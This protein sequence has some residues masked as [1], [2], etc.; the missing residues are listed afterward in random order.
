[1]LTAT[2]QRAVD[3]FAKSLATLSD[4][5]RSMPIIRLG[6]IIETP[7]PRAATTLA[8][9]A[10]RAWQPKPRCDIALRIIKAVTRRG[11]R[12]PCARGRVAHEEHNAALATASMADDDL[13]IVGAYCPGARNRS[14][15][16]SRA[17][18]YP[19][20]G[21][22]P[23]AA[24]VGTLALYPAMVTTLRHLHGPG[25]TTADGMNWCRR[26]LQHRSRC[27]RR[28]AFVPALVAAAGE[29][30]S[31]RFLEFFAAN[32][33]N[34]HTRRAYCPRRGGIPGLVRERR[35]AVDRRRPAG[36]CRD[37]DRG[38]R[39]ASWPRR[40]SSNGSPRSAICSIGWSTARSCRSTRRI[41]ARAAPRRHD[42]AN[43]GARSGRSAR[44]ARQHR[45]RR[46]MPACA[47]A[48]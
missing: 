25:V 26:R 4:D 16:R 47:T 36:A 40:A 5:F 6:R 3:R 21:S 19:N 8:K 23:Y 13:A 34:P 38:R 46:R 2:Q 43:A 18:G 28:E 39:R 35:R 41:G 9:P 10:P 48:R 27:V 20:M 7:M 12:E 14:R 15:L 22:P 11:T 17:A 45:Y 37:V 31:M 42:R 33:R 29:R 30:A 24:I 1:M 44:A 32:I